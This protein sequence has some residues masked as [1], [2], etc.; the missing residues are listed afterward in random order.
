MHLAPFGVCKDSG[1]NQVWSQV[2][3][4]AKKKKVFTLFCTMMYYH[5]NCNTIKWYILK[6]V[7]SDS[8]KG[9]WDN[10]PYTVNQTAERLFIISPKFL[11]MTL[12]PSLNWCCLYT[13]RL[14]FCIK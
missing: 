9:L 8:L 7:L 11:E 4:V 2:F 10:A 12:F 6:E 5:Q 14:D 3:W 1:H 13:V